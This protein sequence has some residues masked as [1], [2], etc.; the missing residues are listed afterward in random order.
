MITINQT[1][2]NILYGKLFSFINSKQLLAL[3]DFYNQSRQSRI[4]ELFDN[5]NIVGN[6]SSSVANFIQDDIFFNK[7]EQSL[8]ELHSDLYKDS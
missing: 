6:A 3:F 1:L 5:N 4:D 2:H 8:A 7:Y